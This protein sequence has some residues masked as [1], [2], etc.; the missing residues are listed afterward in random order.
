[1]TIAHFQNLV[2]GRGRATAS[3]LPVA[4]DVTQE[5]GRKAILEAALARHRRIDGLVNNVGSAFR[6]AR[7]EMN[8]I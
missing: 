7:P 6:R 8:K 5:A 4:A 2:F 3:L 1:M